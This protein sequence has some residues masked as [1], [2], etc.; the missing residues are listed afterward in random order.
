MDNLK[1]GEFYYIVRKETKEII[2]GKL[3]HISHDAGISGY[4]SM[5]NEASFERTEFTIYYQGLDIFKSENIFLDL[6][7]S[8]NWIKEESLKEFSLT[9]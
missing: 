3:V 4:K 8:E 9:E 6:E 5:G 7:A 1:L 2:K